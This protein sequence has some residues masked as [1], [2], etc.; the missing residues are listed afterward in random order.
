MLSARLMLSQTAL[1][2]GALPASA[3]AAQIAVLNDNCELSLR[4]NEG[5]V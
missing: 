4:W 5:A 3:I 2:T 1:A